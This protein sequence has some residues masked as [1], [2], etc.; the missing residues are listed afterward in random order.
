MKKSLGKLVEQKCQ[1][2]LLKLRHIGTKMNPASHE[3]RNITERNKIMFG[4]VGMACVYFTYG[5]HHYFNV[6]ARHPK[7]KDG[8]VLI[9]AIKPEKGIKPMQKN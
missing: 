7:V 4:E 6:V 1:E 9:R 3:F 5:M 2:L 8:A